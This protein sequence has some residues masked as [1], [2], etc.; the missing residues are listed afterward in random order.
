MLLTLS[1]QIPGKTAVA[2]AGGAS[3]GAAS[4]MTPA[5][6]MQAL[7]DIFGRNSSGEG[8]TTT[9]RKKKSFW[10]KLWPF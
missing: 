4:G 1:R 8:Q 9:V 2:A 3:A 10:S 7:G 6:S 5:L